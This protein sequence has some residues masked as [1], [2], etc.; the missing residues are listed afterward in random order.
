MTSIAREGL[1]VDSV[2]RI[3]RT[4]AL[5]EHLALPVAAATTY[6]TCCD[7]SGRHLTKIADLIS[8]FGLDSSYI[9]RSV[10]LWAGRIALGLGTASLVPQRIPLVAHITTAPKGVGTQLLF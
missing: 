2:A 5:N 1:N 3:V 9:T 4:T 7:T 10:A 6:L 8:R